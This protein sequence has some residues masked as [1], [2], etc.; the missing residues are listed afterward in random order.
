MSN[1]RDG[2]ADADTLTL[3]DACAMAIG[4]MVG[5]GI[6]AV[7]GVAVQQAGNAA[8]VSF[9]MAGL[10]ALITGLSY[11]RLTLD[12]DE[13]GG[14]FSYVEEIVGAR[15][16]GTV[17]WV[18]LLGYVFTMS[19]YAHTFGAYAARLAGVAPAW[20]PYVGSIIL[21]MLAG[22]NLMGVRES[23]VTED[24][25]VGGKVI[26][27]LLV[28]GAGFFAVRRGEALPV[29]ESGVGLGGTLRAAALIFVAY[30]GFQ[31][32]TYDYDD[33]AHHHTNFPR[34]IWISIPVVIL[35]YMVIAFVTTGGLE[36]SVILQHK[37][38]VLAYVAQPVLGQVGIVA[39]LIA[40]VLSTASAINATLFACARLARRVARDRQ[41]PAVLTRW[42]RGG[43]PVPF[44]VLAS[45]V[46]L[47]VQFGGS[48]EQITTFSSLVF[49]LVFAVVNGAALW[50]RAFGGWQRVLPLV[51][52][53]G[54]LAAT[55]LLGLDTYRTTPTT[56]W[57]IGGISVGLAA[58]RVLFV[59]QGVERKDTRPEAS[60]S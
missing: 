24:L 19:L 58:L 4:G 60:G 43:V 8:F 46:A 23:G 56:L 28:A 16:G 2:A 3:F 38:T 51:G 47:L 15:A 44:V 17:S 32:L 18:L 45:G 36:A 41:L 30:E 48:L 37:E 10:L 35:I 7:L 42:Q 22:V 20:S 54:C 25:L 12:F 1:Q 26:I 59:A 52:G 55:A 57:V 6:F 53:V 5:G 50:H 9:G 27:L 34:A 29:F 11:S 40:A 31:L 33:I 14:S 21:V 39:V 49:L 13:P